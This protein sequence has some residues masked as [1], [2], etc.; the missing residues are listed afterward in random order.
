MIAGIIFIVAGI[1]IAA[2][3]QLLSIIV[4]AFLIMMGITL[5]TMSYHFKKVKK[6]FDNPFMDFFTRY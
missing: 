2:Y 5:A 6:D 3:P 1:L 4:A